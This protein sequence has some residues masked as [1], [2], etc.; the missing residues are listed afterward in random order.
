MTF[1][2]ASSNLMN[3]NIK[4]I[5]GAVYDVAHEAAVSEYGMDSL[6]TTVQPGTVLKNVALFI[7]S[8]RAVLDKAAHSHAKDGSHWCVTYFCTLQK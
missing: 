6:L 7:D 8:T 2:E 3:S 4:L 1:L 5:K